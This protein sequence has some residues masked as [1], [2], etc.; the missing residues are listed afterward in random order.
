[1]PRAR[2]PVAGC[3]SDGH[4]IDMVR[5]WVTA[6]GRLIDCHWVT[7][8]QATCATAPAHRQP[9]RTCGASPRSGCLGKSI[10]HRLAAPCA[11]GMGSGTRAGHSLPVDQNELIGREYEFAG[12]L[13]LLRRPGVRL[14]TLS[15]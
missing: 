14:V 7:S 3:A 4:L 15:G 10:E 6:S 5:V 13:D 11:S 2:S 9:Y 1:M 8:V 12:V